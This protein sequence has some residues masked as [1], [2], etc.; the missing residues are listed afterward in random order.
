MIFRHS[1]KLKTCDLGREMSE[2][3][4]SEYA[5]DSWVEKPVKFITL[6][7]SSFNLNLHY[8][9]QEWIIETKNEINIPWINSLVRQ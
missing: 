8:S 4:E 2:I 1:E 5:I 9:F 7:R 6:P 3:H